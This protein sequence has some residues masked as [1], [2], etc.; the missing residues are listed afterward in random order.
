MK[1][2]CQVHYPGCEQQRVALARAI[3]IEPDVLLL[4]EPLSNLDAQLRVRMRKELRDIQKETGITAVYVTHDQD[5]ALSMAD[6]MA[7]LKEG[8]IIQEGTPKEIYY[9]PKD[10]F[11]AQFIGTANIFKVSVT[12]QI[13]NTQYI[14]DSSIGIMQIEDLKGIPESGKE[15]TVCIRPESI[16]VMEDNPGNNPNS[17]QAVIQEI[18]FYGETLEIQL[19]TNSGE[20]IHALMSNS[21][22]YHWVVGDTISWTI[23]PGDIIP[24]NS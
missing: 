22:G 4:D 13:D 19:R 21:R 16:K 14:V 10:S 11:I 17:Y 1:S 24:L 2:E 3:V 15:F 5:E 23:N 7:V 6:R 8:R 9:H 12:S 20:R 18:R